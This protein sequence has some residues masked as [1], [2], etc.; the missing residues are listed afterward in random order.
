MPK[1]VTIIESKPPEEDYDSDMALSPS[2][3]TESTPLLVRSTNL[4]QSFRRQRSSVRLSLAISKQR[5]D[6]ASPTEALA[7]LFSG[8]ID[9]YQDRGYVPYREASLVKS[10]P[11]VHPYR[12]KGRHR[13]FHLFWLNVSVY[14]F[15]IRYVYLN[16]LLCVCA[17]MYC[18]LFCGVAM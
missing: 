14:C 6:F 4:S 5:Q 15:A 8:G 1:E 17:C 9:S 10:V 7:P 18:S 13:N 3:H 12:R 11:A 16:L 2:P